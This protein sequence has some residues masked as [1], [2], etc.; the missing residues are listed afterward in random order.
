MADT[1]QLSMFSSEAPLA[2]HFQS[3]GS[4]ADWLTSVVTWHSN[5]VG[6]LSALAPSGSFGKMSPV[7]S[8]W[9]GEGLLPPSSAGFQ[10][11]GMVSP[12]ECWTLSL[13]EFTGLDGLSLND[14]GV[15]SLSDILET[16][17]VPQRYYLS[18]TACRG[19]LRRAAKRGKELSTLLHRALSVVAGASRGAATHEGKT[20]LLQSIP[21]ALQAPLVRTAKPLGQRHRRTP[22]TDC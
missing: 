17:D 15:C 4:E 16:G 14:D 18:A 20:Q 8:V 9:T 13:S 19:I 2:N 12:T 6:L 22:K 5:F 10:N 11:A 1:M 21:V 7:C 3:P